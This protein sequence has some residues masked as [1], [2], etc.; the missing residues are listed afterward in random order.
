MNLSPDLL[1]A[2]FVKGKMCAR[3]ILN[4]KKS[5]LSF[6][7]SFSMSSVC[8]GRG[9]GDGVRPYLIRNLTQRRG[10]TRTVEQLPQMGLLAVRD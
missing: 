8:G 10:A 2:Q 7:S 9:Q 4:K 6:V 1:N 5:L 3:K